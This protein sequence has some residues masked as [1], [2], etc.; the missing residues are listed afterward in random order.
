M[1]INSY[2]ICFICYVLHM[3]E[4][5][6]FF[7]ILYL[8]VTTVFKLYDFDNHTLRVKQ[9]RIWLSVLCFRTYVTCDFGFFPFFIFLA[10]I[11]FCMRFYV[12]RA[13]GIKLGGRFKDNDHDL[14]P[15]CGRS[16]YFLFY[17]HWKSITSVLILFVPNDKGIN[18]RNLSLHITSEF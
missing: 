6:F 2:I 9:T 5:V 1:K 12:H 16:S 3:R 8:L 18:R 11:F 10:F 17:R 14:L 7:S 15:T 4:Y 13:P